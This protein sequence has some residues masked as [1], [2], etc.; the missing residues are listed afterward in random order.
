MPAYDYSAVADIYDDFCV[1]DDDITFFREQAASAG[2]AVLELMAGTG[3]V[4]GPMSESGADLTCVDICLPMLEVLAGKLRGRDLDARLVCA[5]IRR[6]P[7]ASAFELAV[8]PFQGFTE[9]VGRDSQLA[10]LSEV[11]RLLR[12]G[13]RFVCTSHNPSVRE[14]TVD[15]RWRELGRFDN[16]AGRTLVLSFRA[17]HSDRPGVVEGTQKIE[18]FDDAGRSI[19]R[20]VIELE[21]SLVP[22]RAIVDMAGSVG[23][24]LE[25]LFGDYHGAP[26]DESSSPAVIAVF[27]RAV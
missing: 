8:L 12:P 11:A 6:M 19:E 2:G 20:R 22:A 10:M 18:I 14:S 9:L 13:G 24:G 7:F 1:F 16:R 25:R 27:E 26:F 5:D 21:F 15:G 3:R 23:L 4:S 17:V